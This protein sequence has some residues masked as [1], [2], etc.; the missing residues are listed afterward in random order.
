MSATPVRF[1]DPLSKEYEFTDSMLVRCPRCDGM[2]HFD[3]R[4]AHAPD[5]D[6]VSYRQRRLV[7]PS[8][9]LARNPS[10]AHPVLWLRTRTRHGEVWAYNLEHLDLLRR[11][12]AASLRER[13][14][15]YEHGRKMTYVARLPAWIKRAKN[16]DEVLRAI[17][18]I[19]ASV[20]TG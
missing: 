12:V 2:A 11:F 4:P 17:D 15:W 9:G 13:P 3:R 16:R 8:C 14:P 20:V 6:A 10:C 1:R 19:R 7:C 5:A 18:R